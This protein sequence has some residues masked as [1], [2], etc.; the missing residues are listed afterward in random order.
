[1]NTII[2]IIGE[3]KEGEC[4]CEKVCSDKEE[5]IRD[6][7][8]LKNREIVPPEIDSSILNKLGLSFQERNII[9]EKIIEFK[10]IQKIGS[11]TYRIDYDYL[12]DDKELDYDY[13][14][15]KLTIKVIEVSEVNYQNHYIHTVVE[16]DI[17]SGEALDNI[18]K[19]SLP[20]IAQIGTIDTIS[21]NDFKIVERKNGFQYSTRFSE[22]QIDR[23]EKWLFIKQPG[24]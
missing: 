1:M 14:K 18:Y 12:Y 3:N 15:D 13:I 9:I 21:L 20:K 5:A 17:T 4:W 23:P 16:L 11:P 6:I 8:F 2:Y 24:D 7:E 22:K 10:K 19:I